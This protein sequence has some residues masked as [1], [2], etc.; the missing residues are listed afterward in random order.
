V[1]AK[2]QELRLI[3]QTQ[4]EKALEDKARELENERESELAE[5]E[6][7]ATLPMDSCWSSEYL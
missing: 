2:E 6:G 7:N 5:K 3:F 1:A 4:L